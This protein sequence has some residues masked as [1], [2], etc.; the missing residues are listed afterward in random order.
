MQKY[1][2]DQRIKAVRE[3]LDSDMPKQTFAKT[4]GI[5]SSTFKGWVSTYKRFGESGFQ[6]KRHVNYYSYETKLSAVKAYKNGE[7]S[8]KDICARFGVKST[9]QLRYWLIQ[10]N[11]DKNLTVVHV[12]KRVIQIAR[13]T[14]LEERIEVV[15][16]VTKYNHSYAEASEH[17][18]VSYQQARMWV[19][20]ANNI[21]YTALVDNRG[22]N[23]KTD[24]NKLSEVDELK[25]EIR[26]LK[27]ELNRRDAIEAFEKK[28]NEIQHGE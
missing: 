24:K 5:P 17:F 3:Y 4:R 18:K 10:Y 27:N 11:N 16:Y 14:T 20:K 26:Q 9:K 6:R 23:K 1:T 7:G 12:G 8:L 21:G 25:L 22:K 19:L 13:K 28:L 2:V 15:E